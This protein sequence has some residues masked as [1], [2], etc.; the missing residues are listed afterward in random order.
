[1]GAAAFA[2]VAFG[3]SPDGVIVGQYV[4]VNGGVPHGFLALPATT[5]SIPR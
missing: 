5:D 2:T 3:I 4:P 1:L